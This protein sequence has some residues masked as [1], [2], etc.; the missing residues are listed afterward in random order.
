MTLDGFDVPE[1]RYARGGGLDIAYQVMGTGA[2][3]PV[4]AGSGR[5]R[6]GRAH[7]ER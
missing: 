6:A 3:D 7:V 5:E 4:L 1:T 2:I